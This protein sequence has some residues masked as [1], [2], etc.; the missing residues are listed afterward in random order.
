MSSLSLGVRE[1]FMLGI[2]VHVVLECV[3]L[4][5]KDVYQGYVRLSYKRNVRNHDECVVFLQT[6][7]VLR[8]VLK[9]LLCD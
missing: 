2:C 7:N 5:C 6:Q 3:K 4:V 8:Q 9:D 1:C